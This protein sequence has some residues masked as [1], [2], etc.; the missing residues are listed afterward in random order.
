M[1]T[2]SASSKKILLLVLLLLSMQST[3]TAQITQAGRV[4]L[5]MDNQDFGERFKAIGLE[6]NGIMVYRRLGGKTEDQLELTK[7]DTTLH[8][9]WK[10]YIGIPKNLTLA[11]I[12]YNKDAQVLFILFKQQYYLG[13]D[14]QMVSVRVVNG[15]FGTYTIKNL[16]PFNPTEFVITSQ[17]A[18][19]GGYFN[20]RPLVLY[21]NFLLK[22][23]KILPGFFNEQGEI[24]QMK[25]YPDGSLDVVV[26]ARNTEKRKS[27]WIRNYDSM[28][29]LVKTTMLEPDENKNL[30]FGRSVKLSNG[31]QIVAGVYG[32]FTDYSR[33]IF[34]AG[35]NPVGEYGIRYYNFGELKNFFSYMKAKRQKRIKDRIERRTVRGKKVKFNYRFLIHDIIPYK[36]QYIMTGEAFY[37]HYTYPSN[38]NYGRSRIYYPNFSGFGPATRADLVFDGYQYTHAVVVG[39]DNSGK[40]QWDNSFEINDVKTMQ[41]EQFVQVKPEKDRIVLMYLFDN[42][43]RSKIIHDSEVLEGKTQDAIK[44]N[45]DGETVDIRGI[46]SEQLNYWYGKYFYAFGVQKLKQGPITTR[47]IFFVNKLTYN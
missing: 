37:P 21:Y 7:M 22:Q 39:F 11:Y 23:S 36:D 43:L 29:E 9:D 14:F 4:E 33:G 31:E 47:R 15:N 32:R 17:A 38:Y 45:T 2:G 10:G 8:E 20:Y 16:I 3:L 28:G 5:Q 12:Q 24:N 41:L 42:K 26:C 18:M 27:L 44:P 19:V 25:V 30:L 13:G 35:I 40:I 34:V 6:E 46:E 1:L